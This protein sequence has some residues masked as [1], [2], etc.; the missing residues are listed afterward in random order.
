MAAVA[1]SAEAVGEAIAIAT[2]L[3]DLDAVAIAG[4]FAQV[5]DDY[6]ERVAAAAHAAAPHPYGRGVR[7]SG[8]T[9]SGDGPLLGAAALA[10]RA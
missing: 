6:V 2:T 3:Y 9:L 4:G 5:A 7:I 8:S 10:L 1:R